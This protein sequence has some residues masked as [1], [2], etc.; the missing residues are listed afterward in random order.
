MRLIRVVT[1]LSGTWK[2]LYSNAGRSCGC[3]TIAINLY[4]YNHAVLSREVEIYKA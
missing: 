2:S 1:A 4:K 3:A